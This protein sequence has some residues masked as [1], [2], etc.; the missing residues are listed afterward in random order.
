[1]TQTNYER[2]VAY[3]AQ[4]GLGA[5]ASGA[6]AVLL[7]LNSGKGQGETSPVSSNESRQDGMI[8]RGRHGNRRT[9]GSYQGE[10]RLS[11]YDDILAAIMRGEWTAAAS[12]GGDQGDFVGASLSVAQAPVGS[13][14]SFNG[15]SGDFLTLN[16]GPKVGD[17]IV[18]SSGLAPAA[19]NRPLVVTHVTAKSLS[20]SDDL[21]VLSGPQSSWSFSVASKLINPPA[22]ALKTTYFT[23]EERETVN[24]ASELFSDVRW[25]QVQ[26]GM[27]P[28][29]LLT[30]MP[31]WTG[32]GAM[33]VLSGADG[34]NFLNPSETPPTARIAAVDCIVMVGDRLLTVS[35][36]DLTV[37]IGL[38]TY[39]EANSRL[40]PGVFDAP[41]RISGSFACL[42]RDLGFVIDSLSEKPLSLTLVAQPE[43]GGKGFLGLHI[44]NFTIPIPNKSEIAKEG[45]PM[46]QTIDIIAELVGKD[47]AGAGRDATMIKFFRS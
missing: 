26:I 46:T 9:Q 38:T 4:T 31:S 22:G 8:T 39:D 28:N 14:I 47:E 40:S 12:F 33:E 30:F 43:G 10:Y 44:G 24:E 27:Q 35:S 3:K 15:G 13:V 34:V 25:G 6:G 16:G 29:G 17:A 18:F 5:K 1:M 42:R 23:I 32:T 7:S 11:A 21:A 41:M 45:G 36:L 20:V 19:L 37:T 2:Y